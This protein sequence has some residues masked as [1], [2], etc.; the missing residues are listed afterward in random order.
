MLD[1]LTYQVL[2]T[3]A[4]VSSSK[5]VK[6]FREELAELEEI[7]TN[8]VFRLLKAEAFF[9]AI[10]NNENLIKESATW[11]KISDYKPNL[12]QK[13]YDELNIQKLNIEQDKNQKNKKTEKISKI[14]T[15]Y[16]TWELWKK[17][18]SL[19]EIATER[20]LS[21]STIYRHLGLLVKEG[22][23]QIDEIFSEEKIHEL[24]VV[25]EKSD[26]DVTLTHIKEQVGE[27]FSWEEL[28]L[29]KSFLNRSN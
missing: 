26:N 19:K 14:A 6:Q 18:I 21:L 17:K 28:H 3:Q 2:R 27:T 24:K 23:I 16:Q 10:C 22:K 8:A 7:Q 15:Q 25:F 9:K 5:N 29:F 12:L 1:D 13:I 11:K 20:K 4:E